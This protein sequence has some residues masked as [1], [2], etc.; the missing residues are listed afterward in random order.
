MSTPLVPLDLPTETPEPEDVIRSLQTPHPEGAE[1]L[2]GITVAP[3]SEPD[4]EDSDAAK[5]ARAKPGRR[6]SNISKHRTKPELLVAA[7]ELDAENAQLRRELDTLKGVESGPMGMSP[8]DVTQAVRQA[9]DATIELGSRIAA[10]YRGD[11]WVIEG[12]EREVLR[13]AWVPILTAYA[14]QLGQALPWVGALSTTALVLLP[15]FGKDADLRKARAVTAPVPAPV[16]DPETE[17]EEQTTAG[18][19]IGGPV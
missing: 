11:H 1:P 8:Q 2:G 12:P 16:A 10:A 17:V 13:D 4:G 19:H 5:L 18:R 9:L 14:P 7:R 15:R 3:E 6:R